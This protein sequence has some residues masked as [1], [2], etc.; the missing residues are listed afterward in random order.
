MTQ[1]TGTF[2]RSSSLVQ[3]AVAGA[4]VTTV[5]V[6]GALLS[7]FA[8]NSRSGQAPAA[9]ATIVNGARPDRAAIVAR[10]DSEYLRQIAGAWYIPAAPTVSP[11]RAAIVARLD[12][13]YLREIARGW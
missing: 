8:L 12:S 2:R 3:A 6:V 5:I 10:L 13:E 7:A 1:L 4:L 9:S 11:D